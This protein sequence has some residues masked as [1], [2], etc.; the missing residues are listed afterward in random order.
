MRI[1]LLKSKIHGARVTD[2][3]IHYTG[4]I[5]IDKEL[6]EKAQILPFEKVLVVSLDSGERLETYVI[7]GKRNSAEICIN[8]AAA[9]KILKGENIIIM[10]FAS[11]E[12]PEAIKHKPVVI[13]VDENNAV[14]SVHKYVDKDDEC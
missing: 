8:G 14:V 11:M 5:T 13:H 2:A 3:Q 10:A 9:R 6:M 12:H 4:S 7:E 1:D